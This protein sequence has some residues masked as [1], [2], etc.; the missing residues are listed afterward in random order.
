MAVPKGRAAITIATVRELPEVIAYRA[1]SARG[2]PG[3][4]GDHEQDRREDEQV[5][6][7]R[8]WG[9]SS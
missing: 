6:A 4:P 7:M 5:L 2:Q 1:A 3:R 8:L 9:Y